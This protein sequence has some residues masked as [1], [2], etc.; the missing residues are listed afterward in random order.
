MTSRRKAFT[1]LG[2]MRIR[3][4]ISL[5]E[6]PSIS[7]SVVSCSVASGGTAGLS[8]KYRGALERF[9]RAGEPCSLQTNRLSEHRN[10]KPGI[11]N[12]SSLRETRFGDRLEELHCFGGAWR[13]SCSR[14]EVRGTNYPVLLDTTGFE[15]PRRSR[16]SAFVRNRPAGSPLP[17]AG[18]LRRLQNRCSGATLFLGRRARSEAY[19]PQ[20]SRCHP[21]DPSS[22]RGQTR[23]SGRTSVWA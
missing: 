17:S 1:V 10:G 9:V 14:A 3:L 15:L 2:L 6:R 21:G 19:N 11:D 18:G 20:K 12:A 8:P 16:R 4:A 22:G 13:G 23:S 5:L 7:S